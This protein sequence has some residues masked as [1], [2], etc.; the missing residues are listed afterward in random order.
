MKNLLIS[1]LFSLPLP[2]K[3]IPAAATS[4]A[5]AENFL[6]TLDPAQ[7]TRAALPFTS[8]ERENFRYTPRDR[9]GLP[10]KEMTDTQREAVEAK[11]AAPD[12]K[13][14]IQVIAAK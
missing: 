8:E 14:E 10:L 13:V 5:A 2:A 4:T 6:A 9:A 11:L 7:K 3:E 1:L 12:Y